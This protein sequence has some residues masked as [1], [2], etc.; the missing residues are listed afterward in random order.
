MDT[1]IYRL[2]KGSNINMLF[3]SVGTTVAKLYW[4][5]SH[6]ETDKPVKTSEVGDKIF[7]RSELSLM[8]V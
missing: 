6:G 8:L 2:S 5:D 7:L 3:I 1:Q 4:K